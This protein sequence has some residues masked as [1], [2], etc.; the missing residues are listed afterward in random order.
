MLQKNKPPS[1][2][3]T[4]RATNCTSNVSFCALWAGWI[5]RA[6]RAMRACQVTARNFSWLTNCEMR[7]QNVPRAR[8]SPIEERQNLLSSLLFYLIYFFGGFLFSTKKKRTP[9]DLRYDSFTDLFVVRYP[10][11]VT[12]Q[13]KAFICP[14]ARVH[15]CIRRCQAVICLRLWSIT[16]IRHCWVCICLLL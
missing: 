15:P 14:S 2:P 1:F 9:N 7:F 10:I 3:S 6:P 13:V 4:Y 16:C 5:Q 11:Q 8:M 12:R